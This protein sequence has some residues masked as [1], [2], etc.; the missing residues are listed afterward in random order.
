MSLSID[1]YSVAVDAS[2]LVSSSPCAPGAP[3]LPTGVPI[4]VAPS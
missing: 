1:V 3:A 2:A 4:Q